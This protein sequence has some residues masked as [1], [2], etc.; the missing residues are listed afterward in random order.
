MFK[1]HG[2]HSWCM[3]I[4][5][6]GTPGSG[7]STLARQLS[8]EL[9]IDHV[10]IGEL[11]REMARDEGMTLHELNELGEEEAWT[12]REIDEYQQEY[13]EEHDDF[14]MESRLGWYFVEDSF[15]IFVDAGEQ[16]RA[17]RIYE[18]ESGQYDSVEEVR[19]ATR[20]RMQSD[21]KRY[22]K[23]YDIDPY[24]PEHYDLVVDST[25]KKPAMVLRIVLDALE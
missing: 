24:R 8:A 18:R 6:G 3:K 4:T 21:R 16:E 5:I 1:T 17:R 25:D 2:P 15:D 22:R 11:R 9:G 10:S 14:I 13:A 12:D 19:E 23:Y 7:K 20:E